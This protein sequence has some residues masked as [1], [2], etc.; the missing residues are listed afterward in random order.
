MKKRTIRTCG[1]TLIEAIM[2]VGIITLV[3]GAI[4]AFQRT[5]IRNT[6]I[7]QSALITEQQARKTL[8]SFVSEMREATQSAAGSYA[9]ESAGTSSIV[10]YSNVDGGTDVERVRYFLATSTAG[11]AVYDVVKKGVIKAV[12]VTYPAGSETFRTVATAVKNTSLT[13]LFTYYDTGYAGTSTALSVPINIP[14][15]RLIKL[16]LLVD[17]NAALSPVPQTYSTQVS[18]R[19]LK[20][21]L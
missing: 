9:I 19:N 16:E 21:N 2:V 7:I 17:P 12:G 8:S 6:R 3:G 20:S 15:V 4:V 10:F 18:I 13:P 11:S 5:V 14:S 1:F